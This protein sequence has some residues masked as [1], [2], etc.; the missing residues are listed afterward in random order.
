MLDC[1]GIWDATECALGKEKCGFRQDRG[2]MDQ[3][4]AVRQVCDKYL[5]N[6]KYVFW[7]STV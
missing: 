7:V 5:E 6:R 1:Q 2:C 3:V 4:F